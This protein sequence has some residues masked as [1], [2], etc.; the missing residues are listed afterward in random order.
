[1]ENTVSAKQ[2]PLLQVQKL[3]VTFATPEGPVPA[4]HSVSFNLHAGKTLALVGESGSGK[5]VTAYSL[6]RLLPES[7]QLQGDV[8]YG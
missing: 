4:V 3:S 5:S 6:L 7:A 2:P 1:M 8:R